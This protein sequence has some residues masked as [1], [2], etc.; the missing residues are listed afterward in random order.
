MKVHQMLGS[1]IKD[2]CS[3]Q[4]PGRH[5]CWR[6]M[7]NYRGQFEANRTLMYFS[8]LSPPHPPHPSS[9]GYLLNFWTF[10]NQMWYCGTSM[11]AGVSWERTSIAIFRSRSQW[12]FIYHI[13]KIWPFVLCLLMVGHQKTKCPVKILG[14]CVQGQG[15]S[16]WSNFQSYIWMISSE[17]LNLL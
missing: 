12:G 2:I 6:R 9:P 8:V 11:W 10:C 4:H 14:C 5:L 3:W 16:E 17:L 15:H 7:Y 1:T 13:M